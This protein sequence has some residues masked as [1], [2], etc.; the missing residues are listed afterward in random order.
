MNIDR[1]SFLGGSALLLSAPSI[2]PVRAAADEKIVMASWGGGTAKMWRDIFG[3]S[4]TA[5]S[6]IPVTVAEVPDP[7]AAVAAAQGRPQH[8][9]II[10]A[11]FQ[12]ANLA[13][14]GLIET[15]S[16]ADLPNIK[17]VPEQYWVRNTEG[18]L[19][20]M[21]IYF[22]YYGIAYNTSMCKA[23]DFDSWKTLADSKWKGKLSVTRPIF[24]APYDLTICSKVMGGSE[25]DINPGVPLLRDIVRN[26]VSAYTSMA[27]LQQQ[28]AQGEVAAAPFYSSQVQLLRR[29]GELGVDIAIPKEGGLVLSYVLAVPKGSENRAAAM[30]FLN[31][32]I[33]PNNQVEAARNAYLP[34]STNVTL[35]DDVSKDYGMSIGDVRGRNWAPNWYSVAGDLE[36]RMRLV[37]QIGDEAA[38]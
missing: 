2:I 6:S 1:R 23:S 27:S 8:N 3:R 19:V 13:Q 10:A 34:L 4:F 21:P 25:V 33:S 7:S 17:H 28:L 35:P 11:S 36:S 15:F 14:R 5:A 37:Q 31:D 29:S 20:G 16:E 26:A 18:R 24:M 32:A 38:R 22:I 9:V 30:R 12:G